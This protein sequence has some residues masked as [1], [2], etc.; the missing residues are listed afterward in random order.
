MTPP[1]LAE[2]EEAF[3][4]H[5]YLPDPTPLHLV[6]GS[7]VAN[8]LDEDPMWLILVAPPS[9]G[10]TEF[11]SALDLF[12]DTHGFSN[13]TVAGMATYSNSGGGSGGLLFRFREQEAGRRFG[14]ITIKEL[15]T[16]LGQAARDGGSSALI[17]ALREVYDGAFCRE[18]GTAGGVEIPWAGKAGLVA[19][20]T[21]VIDD[22]HETI[23]A[24]GDRF[25]LYRFPPT[26]RA[27]RFAK[28]NL[29]RSRAN[30]Q[31]TR[32]YLAEVVAAF[33]APFIDRG[34]RATVSDEE[35][36]DLMVV[37]DLTTRGRTHLA[38]DRR[39]GQAI[40]RPQAE[41]P[42]RL[43]GALCALL[44]GLR[45]IGVEP[46]TAWRHVI[47]CAFASMPQERCRIMDALVAVPGALSRAQVVEAAAG[48]GDEAVTWEL[49]CLR[50]YGLVER[51]SGEHQA[52]RYT[53]SGEDR[54]TWT[55]FRPPMTAA[56]TASPD[57]IN[58][59]ADAGL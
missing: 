10:K 21:E 56:P 30:P 59:D 50:A 24:M 41:E 12:G 5:L 31:A 28:C 27:E 6:L 8:Y 37:A 26:T 13:S 11:V 54:D 34:G 4:E 51:W 16:I 14:V 42:T 43:F 3:R 47:D 1:K 46:A 52:F 55:T 2:V 38:R 25:V 49:D 32:H 18:L 53:A 58:V 45:L 17:D 57:A 19:A 33:L 20:T 44:E 40:R 48:A 29:I 15:G 23:A 9:S 39:S 36:V 22:H 7:V 35:A